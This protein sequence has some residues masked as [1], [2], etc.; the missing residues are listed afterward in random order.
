MVWV[1]VWIASRS[2]VRCERFDQG[3]LSVCAYVLAARTFAL[4]S[5]CADA[6]QDEEERCR[7]GSQFILRT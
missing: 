2:A 4:C 6:S 1:L 3:H 5:L 7:E